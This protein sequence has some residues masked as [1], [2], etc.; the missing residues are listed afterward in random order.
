MSV[1][2][3]EDLVSSALAELPD[4]FQKQLNNVDI[5]IEDNPSSEQRRKL[6]LHN[7]MLLLGLYEGIPQTKRGGGYTM[8]LPDKITIFKNP[9]LYFYQSEEQ[10]KEHVRSVVYH[11]IGH[12]FGLSEKRLRELR[13]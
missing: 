2:S 9:I 11:E 8:V 7:R 1:N 13:K 6:R 10:I 12:H 5:V 3:F 4:E